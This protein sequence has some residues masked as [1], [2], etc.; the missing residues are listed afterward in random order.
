MARALLRPS[1]LRLDVDALDEP[2]LARRERAV[3]AVGSGL[4]SVC[5][6]EQGVGVG[7]D[8]QEAR[9]DEP[10]VCR[11]AIG[12]DVEL[13]HF[14]DVGPRIA[15]AVEGPGEVDR[16]VFQRQTGL[17]L[18]FLDEPDEDRAIR[19][20]GPR[21]EARLRGV[22]P[23]QSAQRSVVEVVEQERVAEDGEG[24]RTTAGQELPAL[25]VSGEDRVVGGVQPEAEHRIRVDL[26]VGDPDVVPAGEVRGRRVR[27]VPPNGELARAEFVVGLAHLER[28]H[29]LVG[30]RDERRAERI[31][32]RVDGEADD[33]GH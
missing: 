17:E 20:G 3:A 5:L 21:P 14:L 31:V 4:G 19:L 2:D 1:E 28:R 16:D 11:Q 9:R 29:V 8:E 32:C 7:P 27:V 23:E 24:S 12:A 10:F 13:D 15:V 33:S 26:R 18:A 25:L 6:D 30:Q 22:A